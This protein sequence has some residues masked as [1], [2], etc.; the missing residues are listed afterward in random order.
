MGG[1]EDFDGGDAADRVGEGKVLGEA[2][3]DGDVVVFVAWHFGELKI[4]GGSQR[5]Y[6]YAYNTPSRYLL[7]SNPLDCLPISSPV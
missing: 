7:A 5:I 4:R 3:L 2:D 1:F 6:E